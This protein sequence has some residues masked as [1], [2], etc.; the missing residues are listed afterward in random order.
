MCS[1]RVPR[2]SNPPI[3]ARPMLPP[4]RNANFSGVIALY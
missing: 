3:K 2:W 4:P 1:L